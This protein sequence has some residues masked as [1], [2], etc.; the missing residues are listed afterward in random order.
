MQHRDDS[1]GEQPRFCELDVQFSEAAHPSRLIVTSEG[2]VVFKDRLVA[3]PSPLRGH[4]PTSSIMLALRLS[5]PPAAL[6][7]RMTG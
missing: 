4:V 1:N 5:M 7:Q 3:C 2:R 6:H